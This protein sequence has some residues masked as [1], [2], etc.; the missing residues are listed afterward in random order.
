[1]SEADFR[2]HLHRSLRQHVGLFSYM[3]SMLKSGIPD[4]Y[5][6]DDGRD[7]WLELKAPKTP[8]PKK[9]NVLAHK[10]TGQQLSFLRRVDRAGGRGLGAVGWKED[11]S[12]RMVLLRVHEIGDKGTLTREGVSRHR[13]LSLDDP[14]FVEKMRLVLRR[15]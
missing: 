7:Y 5:I 14:G 4:V 3:A 11:G 15:S 6:L 1:M 2:R 13:I 9:G 8:W 12:W 10:F